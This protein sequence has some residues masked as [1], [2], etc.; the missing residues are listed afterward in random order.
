MMKINGKYAGAVEEFTPHIIVVRP[1]R[2]TPNG[3]RLT[4]RQSQIVN[5][6]FAGQTNKQIAET[7]GISEITVKSHLTTIFR[8][9]GVSSRL[10]LALM[11][12]YYPSLRLCGK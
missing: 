2:S 8:K 1:E 9:L 12:R 6:V 4:V 11:A 10:E 7:Y 3:V 5:T